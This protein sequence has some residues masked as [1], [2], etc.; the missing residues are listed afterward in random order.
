MGQGTR[1]SPLL[2]LLTSP[3]DRPFVQNAPDQSSKM[4]S[5]GIQ[6]LA[7]LR[8]KGVA[9]DEEMVTEKTELLSCI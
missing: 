8:Q 3:P 2:Q 4:C 5:S 1:R 6:Q 7:N 9:T